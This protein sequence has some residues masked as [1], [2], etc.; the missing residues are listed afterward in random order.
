MFGIQSPKTWQAQEKIVSTLEQMQVQNETGQGVRRSK[1]PLLASR[2]RCNV[3]WK[4]GNKVKIGN[5][6]QFGNKFTNVCNVWSI[7]GVTVYGHVLECHVTFGRGREKGRD[8]TQS[9]DKSPYTHRKIKRNNTKKI[10]KTSITERL[11]TDIGRSV[12]VTAVTQV[13]WL[14][15]FTSGK[16]S[17]L[18]QQ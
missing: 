16:P 17:H 18:P 10:T 8:L 3:L 11:R 9:Y 13:M 12:G 5:K 4:F 1:R 6:I 7:E 15:R 2:T 14:N